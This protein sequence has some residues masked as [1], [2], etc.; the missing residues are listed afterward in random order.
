MDYVNGKDYGSVKGPA[1]R[2]VADFEGNLLLEASP[3][4]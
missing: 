3:M 4:Q 1:A 2:L